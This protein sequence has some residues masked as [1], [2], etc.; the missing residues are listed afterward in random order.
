MFGVSPRLI[1]CGAIAGFAAAGWLHADSKKAAEDQHIELLRGLSAEWAK[2]KSILP[3]SKKP[4][5]FNS[6]G[7]WDKQKWEDMTRELGVA[8]KPGELVQVTRVS[9][10]KDAIELELNHG[11]KRQ[12][13]WYDRVQ[14]GTGGPMTPVGDPTAAVAA[15]GTNIVIRFPDGIGNVT[16]ADIKKLLAPVLDFDKR[17]ATDQYA[18]T[19]PPEIKKAVQ[20]KKAIVGMDRDQVLLAL[21]RPVRKSRETTDGEEQEDWI[22]GEPPGRMTFVTFVAN[23]VIRVKETYAGLGGSIAEAPKAQ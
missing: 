12:G 19:L 6:S 5:E 3:R 14:V 10:E 1:A 17:S 4:L 2:A 7:A 13:H 11:T 21:G 22:Y 8:A 20:E 9:I 15:N 18:E 23:K 16:S